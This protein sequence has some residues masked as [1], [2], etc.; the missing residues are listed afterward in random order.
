VDLHPDDK[1]KTAFLMGQV[2]WHFT[3]MPFGLCEASVT[4]ERL[5]RTILG[6]LTY[7]SC[8]MYLD[9]VIVIGRTFQEH[10]VNLRKC[11]SSSE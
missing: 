9:N 10:L 1:E 7:G 11:S 4:S 2:L 5:M 8:F 3:V 6:V